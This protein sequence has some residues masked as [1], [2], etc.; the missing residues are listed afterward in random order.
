MDNR[1]KVRVIGLGSLPHDFSFS[2]IR[3]WH[4]KIFQLSQPIEIF[5]LT[6]N[7]DGSAWE[8]SDKN[9][10]DQLPDSGTEDFLVAIANVP[11]Q[12]NWYTRR[13]RENVVVFTL[14]EIS[15]Y[16]RMN[17]I[18]LRNVILRLLYAYSLGYR[19]SKNRI[20]TS[21]ET[22]NFAHDE[23][24]GCIYDMNGMKYDIIYS[25]DAP[26]ICDACTQRLVSS[27]V[28]ETMLSHAK[29]ELKKIRKEYFFRIADWVSAHPILSIGIASI[30]ALLIGLA[31]EFI[32]GVLWS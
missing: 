26:I 9:I 16:L 15:A 31:T 4:S 20:P 21:D 1:I 13:V 28:S 3:S 10:A 24:K 17:H 7:S 27:G 23:T 25:C 18:P 6:S 30:W 8:F 5:A 14:S 2:G 32:A 12:Y 29:S 11:L 19:G 22:T